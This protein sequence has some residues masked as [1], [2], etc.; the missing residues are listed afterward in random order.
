MHQRMVVIE[1]W[2]PCWLVLIRARTSTPKAHVTRHPSLTR[3]SVWSHRG[4][5]GNLRNRRIEVLPAHTGRRK[6]SHTDI[7]RVPMPIMSWVVGGSGGWN[8]KG[9]VGGGGGRAAHGKGERT[10]K[11][12]NK[13][14][15]CKF[16]RGPLE[17]LNSPFLSLF[18]RGFLSV[19]FI[20]IIRY[21]IG[22]VKNL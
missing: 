8:G 14:A 10:M 2:L 1:A 22:R 16:D 13:G 6:V 18:F 12:R 15:A 17:D 5:Y 20:A 9:A 11:A 19:Q 4:R 21:D 7:R 3:L